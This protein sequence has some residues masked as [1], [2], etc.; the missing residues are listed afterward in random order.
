M[1]KFFLL[2]LLLV[3]FVSAQLAAQSCDPATDLADTVIVFPLPYQADFPERGLTDTACVAADYETTLQIQ[4]PESIS[5]SGLL[6]GVDS[7]VVQ[8]D[9]IPALPESFDYVCN[10]PNCVFDSGNTGCIQIFG[11]AD[12]GDEGTYD[13]KIGVVIYSQIGELQF[14]LPD[15]ILVAG[16]YFFTVKEEGNPNCLVDAREVVE[17]AFDLRIQPNPFSDYADVFVNLPSG[18]EYELSV[19]N[20]V[21]SLVQERTVDLVSGT[22][23]FQFDGSNLATGMY[24]FR[25]QRGSEAASGRLMIQ[26]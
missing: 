26:R 21:G 16:N 20:A 5:F 18:G 9:G 25:L 15:G 24:I 6:V 1:K 13:L 23:S 4:V 19:Y 8:E 3:L 2:P 10:P 17:N 22:N 12:P 7:V 14:D 11:N